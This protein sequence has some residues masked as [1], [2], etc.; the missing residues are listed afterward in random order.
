MQ[1]V[2]DLPPTHREAIREIFLHRRP[3]YT[4]QQAASLLRLN[5]G[6]VLGMLERRELDAPVGRKRKQLGGWKRSLISWKE[7]ASAALIRWPVVQVH[8]ALGADANRVLPRLL[9][10]VEMQSLR[11]PEYQVRLLETWAKREGVTVEQYLSDALLRVEVEADLNVIEKLLP[12][13]RE[14]MEF[15]GA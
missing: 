9:R 13:F 15:P 12:G 7:L 6:E 1:I 3:E 8:D 10:P 2:R 4:V 5:L 11:L 14:A